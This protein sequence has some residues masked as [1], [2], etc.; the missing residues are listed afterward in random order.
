MTDRFA[1]L[2]PLAFVALLA[3]PAVAQN[4]QQPATPG[5]PVATAQAGA[6]AWFSSAGVTPALVLGSGP[7]RDITSKPF[8]AEQV[9]DRVQTLADGTH[10][11]QSSQRTLVYR[12]SEGRTRTDH[13]FTPPSGSD[14]V[15]A[16]S[17]IQIADPVAGCR[18]MLN[19]RDHTAQRMPYAPAILRNGH[20][21]LP[22]LTYLPTSSSQV[23]SAVV[24]SGF[25]G[26][27]LGPPATSASGSRPDMSVESLG[28]QTIDGIVADGART[29][30]TYPEGYFG[31]DR[32][33]T[34]V[35][36]VWN[37]PD[38][39]LAVLTK[40]SDPRSGDTTTKLENISGTDPDPALFQLPPDYTVSEIP[41]SP[42]VTVVR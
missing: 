8:S 22:T 34:T 18:Y 30:V 17:F 42:A 3:S 26:A 15:A 39:Q 16:P 6:S 7:L 21:A 40:T 14:M 37:S 19:P 10:I 41:Q 24:R 13:L 1:F 31:N 5:G 23:P 38:L 25:T 12:D 27:F 20:A 9:T 29:T 2:T 32:P 33:I 11:A 35:T 28:T 4:T 36:E